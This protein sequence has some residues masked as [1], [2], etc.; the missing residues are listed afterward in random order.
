M[1][2]TYAQMM[3]KR[4]DASVV[5]IHD[6]YYN[7]YKKLQVT[8]CTGPFSIYAPLTRNYTVYAP[9]WIIHITYKNG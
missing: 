3:H 7:I 8:D 9:R 1:K 5:S 6:Y 4:C 2:A